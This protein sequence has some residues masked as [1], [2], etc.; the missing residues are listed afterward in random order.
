MG[1]GAIFALLC[2]GQRMWIASERALQVYDVDTHMPLKE[3]SF[4]AFH[5]VHGPDTNAVYVA[6]WEGV[7]IFDEP[8]R[9]WLAHNIRT[10]THKGT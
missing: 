8:V 3:H 9:L 6:V 4:A 10:H 1:K 5:L 7:R 2:L